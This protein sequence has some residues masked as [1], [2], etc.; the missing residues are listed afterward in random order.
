MQH[1]LEI[2]VFQPITVRH[3]LTHSSGIPD[4]TSS[5]FDYATNYSEDDLVRMASDLTLE[6]PAGTRWNY[7]N[8]GYAMLGVMISRVT[9]MPYWDFLRERIFDSAGMPNISNATAFLALPPELAFV[10]GAVATTDCGG[11]NFFWI[12][13]L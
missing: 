4:Y 3:L 2:S 10:P 13:R 5:T 8:T 7:S 12:A 11:A 1:Q 9:G 6:F